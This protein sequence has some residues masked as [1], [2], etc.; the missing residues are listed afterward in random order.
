MEL[1]MTRTDLEQRTII[2]NFG[3]R[4]CQASCAMVADAYIAGSSWHIYLNSRTSA[5]ILINSQSRL[6]CRRI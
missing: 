4:G 6:S 5:Q 3:M 2:E 1:C